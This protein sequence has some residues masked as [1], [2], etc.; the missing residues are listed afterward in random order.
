MSKVLLNESWPTSLPLV[1]SSNHMDVLFK[2]MSN[3]I[4]LF[5]IPFPSWPNSGA[6]DFLKALIIAHRLVTHEQLSI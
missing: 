4:C 1:N 2:S 5:D 6:Y 3:S